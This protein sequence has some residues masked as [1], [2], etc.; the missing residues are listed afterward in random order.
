VV[1]AIVTLGIIA[2]VKEVPG[3]FRNVKYRIG[4]Y[5]FSADDI[6]HGILRCK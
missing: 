6:E 4:K 3:L 2:S 5:I 1:D